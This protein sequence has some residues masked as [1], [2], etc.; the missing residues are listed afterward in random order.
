MRLAIAVV[1]LFA[2]STRSHAADD[3]PPLKISQEDIRSD[4][5]KWRQQA[6]DDAKSFQQDYPKLVKAQPQNRTQLQQKLT[7]AR[8]VI[9][10][11][12]Q[13]AELMDGVKAGSELIPAHWLM[14]YH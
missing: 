10:A 3:L 11:I 6:L 4:V 2:I 7:A 8:K 13:D 9:K 1:A 14:P 5:V 12:E